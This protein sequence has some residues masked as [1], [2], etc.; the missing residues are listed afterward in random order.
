[1]RFCKFTHLDIEVWWSIYKQGTRS[2]LVQVM[3]CCQFCTKPLFVPMLCLLPI[4]LL[5]TNFSGFQ[6]N[7]KKMSSGKLLVI[8][9]WP[10][11]VDPYGAQS[12]TF[13]YNT[14]PI[15]CLHADDLPPGQY[16]ACML[17]TC[18]LALPGHQQPRSLSFIITDFNYLP[19][20]SV[21][22]IE[23]LGFRPILY[24]IRHS[25]WQWNECV[26]HA[27]WTLQ[28]QEIIEMQ[29]YYYSSSTKSSRTR[30]ETVFCVFDK[31]P[32]LHQ[33]QGLSPTWNL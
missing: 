6:I 23:M 8:S 2:S 15:P 32:V 31:L 3:A 12:S 29:I 14:R 9:F 30:V 28:C 19:H 5:G 20:L 4:R 26:K 27:P 13:H 17:M 1:M 33:A 16:H 10:Q 11:H 21:A 18:L 22:K 7:I 24:Q 25:S